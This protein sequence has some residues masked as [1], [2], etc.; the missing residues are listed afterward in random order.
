MGS[1]K[2]S[3]TIGCIFMEIISGDHKKIIYIEHCH[4][5]DYVYE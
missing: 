3:S 2:G 4:I 1:Y 5:L